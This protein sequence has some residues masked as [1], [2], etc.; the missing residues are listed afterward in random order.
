MFNRNS[1]QQ[2]DI[3]KQKEKTTED[4]TKPLTTGGS[5]SDQNIDSKINSI[6]E[7]LKKAKDT[8]D[9]L[10]KLKVKLEEER[11]KNKDKFNEEKEKISHD[12]SDIQEENKV[13]KKQIKEYEDQIGSLKSVVNSLKDDL[14]KSADEFQSKVMDSLKIFEKTDISKDKAYDKHKISETKADEKAPDVKENITPIRSSEQEEAEDS[15]TLQTQTN[16]PDNIVATA[17]TES[18]NDLSANGSAVATDSESI[19]IKLNAAET[20]IDAAP[21]DNDIIEEDFSKYEQI[22]K[23]LEDLEKDDPLTNQIFD[24]PALKD[25]AAENPAPNIEASNQTETLPTGQTQTF[26]Q[27]PNSPLQP[28]ISASPTPNSTNPFPPNNPSNIP[29]I[30][31]KDEKKKPFFL[32]RLLLFPFK[33]LG[34]GKK[35]EVSSAPAAAPVTTAAPTT[36]QNT[37]ATKKG[38]FGFLKREKKEKE[39]SPLKMESKGGMPFIKTA[40]LF[41]LLFA[42]GITYQISN[43]DK[44]RETYIAQ[45]KGIHTQNEEAEKTGVNPFKKED[46]EKRYVEAFTKLPFDKT[47]WQVYEDRGRGFKVNYPKNTS[48]KLNSNENNIVWFLRYNGYLLS[49]E[50]VPTELSME[51]Y[52][53]SLKSNIDYK[54][55]PT[56]L[57][58][59]P[60]LH[61]KLNE[62]MDVKGNYYLI[63]KGSSIYKIWYKTFIPGEDPDDEKRVKDMLESLEITGSPEDN[64]KTDATQA[65]KKTLR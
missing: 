30:E 27:T 19:P 34:F 44:T 31:G 46:P 25:S 24:S 62:R 13:L 56:V 64:Q 26:E 40:I 59:N 63:K 7:Q 53:N 47:L 6:E 41:L 45:V 49:V 42:G 22:K 51:D 29:N 20:A 60:A 43:A 65:K 18:I 38:R 5:F 35:K 55:E 12:L 2:D 54:K 33:L 23:E 17:A 8:F 58:N 3:T 37:E 36:P 10:Q 52:W 21:Q 4:M 48:F 1:M 50:V 61:L 9:E 39:K 32:I 16:A 14:S 11:I 15:K 28:E 57:K